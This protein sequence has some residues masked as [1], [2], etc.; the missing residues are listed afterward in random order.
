MHLIDTPVII[1]IFF[2]SYS[3]RERGGGGGGGVGG[4]RVAVV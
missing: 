4:E 1:G 2:I 3:G